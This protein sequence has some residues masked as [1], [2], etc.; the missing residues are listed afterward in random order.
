MLLSL[1][2]YA[3]MMLWSVCTFSFLVHYIEMTVSTVSLFYI[4]VMN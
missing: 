2:L 3:Y 1:A 4:I